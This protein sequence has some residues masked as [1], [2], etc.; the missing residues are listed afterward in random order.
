MSRITSACVLCC[1]FLLTFEVAAKERYNHWAKEKI[2]FHYQRVQR[3]PHNVGLRVLLS[4][5][6]YDDGKYSEAEEQLNR[7]LELEPDYAEAH[8]NLAIVLQALTRMPEAREHFEVALALDSTLVEAMA[9]LGTLL[10]ATNRQGLGIKYLEK[11]LELDPQRI[12]ARFNIAVAYHKIGDT[13]MAITHLERMME[14]PVKYPG[15]EKALG[16]AYFTRGLTLLQAKKPEEALVTF[17]K[18]FQYATDDEDLYF[19]IGISHLK[20]EQLAN[21]EQAFASAVELDARHVPALHNLAT[22]CERT[23]RPDEARVYYER[24]QDLT[25]HLDSIEAVRNAQYDEEFL[26]R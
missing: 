14:E 18:A 20:L 7:A 25:P 17:A 19:A 24:V 22:V 23:N 15:S 12:S 10:C 4:Q 26:L 16:Q 9:G 2:R 13:R 21:A 6:Y 8:C 1:L 5:A 11:V 3:E